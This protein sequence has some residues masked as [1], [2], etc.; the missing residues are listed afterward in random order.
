MLGRRLTRSMRQPYRSFLPLHS[1]RFFSVEKVVAL[2]E[3][4]SDRATPLSQLHEW[5]QRASRDGEGGELVLN[6]ESKVLDDGKQHWTAEFQ[7]SSSPPVLYKSGSL[8]ETTR[9]T[10]RRTVDGK[11]YYRKRRTAVQAAA[12]R[13]I[14]VIQYH[15]EGSLEPRICAEDPSTL[16]PPPISQQVAEPTST[17]PPR[18]LLNNYFQS[19]HPECLPISK[20]FQSS[21]LM[22]GEGKTWWTASFTSPADGVVY[23]AGS[24]IDKLRWGEPRYFDGKV[25]YPREKWAV[26]AVSARFLDCVAFEMGSLDQQLCHEDPSSPSTQASHPDSPNRE[27]SKKKDLAETIVGSL[28]LRVFEG[29]GDGIRE[30]NKPEVGVQSKRNG[31]TLERIMEAWSDS[32]V[33]PVDETRIASPLPMLWTPNDERRKVLADAETWYC[34]MKPG[35]IP[36]EVQGKYQLFHNPLRLATLSAGNSILWALARVSQVG[37]AFGTDE[38]S[39]EH[40]ASRIVDIL[41]ETCEPTTET[42]NA[43]LRCMEGPTW[44]KIARKADQIFQNMVDEKGGNAG[45]VLPS[46]NIETYNTM[47]MLWARAGG[48]EGKQRCEGL[49]AKIS[50]H[51]TLSPNRTT[52]MNILSCAGTRGTQLDL[53][54]A[55]SWM[56]R[57]SLNGITIDTT[58]CNSALPWSG[59]PSETWM[60]SEIWDD[61]KALFSAGFKDSDAEATENAEAVGEWMVYMKQ[62]HALEPDIVTH[63]AAIQAWVR[64]A[65]RE[66]V[67]KA[68]AIVEELMKSEHPLHSHV[69]AQTVHPI[70]AAHA[71]AGE[72][73][74]KVEE[75]FNKAARMSES[76]KHLVL[77][78]RISAMLGTAWA[79]HAKRIISS[80]KMGDFTRA[81]TAKNAAIK[82][83]HALEEQ[84]AKLKIYWED[85]ADDDAFFV[86]GSNFV[87]IVEMWSDFAV[88]M[89]TAG[90]G[91]DVSECVDEMMKAVAVHSRS[92]GLMRDVRREHEKEARFHVSTSG[93]SMLDL[94]LHHLLSTA[95][96]LYLSVALALKELDKARSESGTVSVFDPPFLSRHAPDLEGFVR[97]LHASNREIANEPTTVVYADRFSYHGDATV[98]MASNGAVCAAI[99]EGIEMHGWSQRAKTRMVATLLEFLL[100]SPSTTTPED[101]SVMRRTADMLASHEALS[102]D[103]TR[104]KLVEH[105][106]EET[107]A[108]NVTDQLRQ[109]ILDAP[110]EPFDN[111]P[112]QNTRGKPKGR[113]SSQWPNLPLD[114][115]STARRKSRGKPKG[116]KGNQRRKKM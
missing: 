51:P 12:A 62:K 35:A 9:K 17:E 57:M 5:Y 18:A 25:Y 29:A 67:E 1:S 116:R 64:T 38:S 15:A 50:S 110:P 43:Y 24:F 33:T 14:D 98:H 106:S 30:T 97:R 31:T 56:E 49:F 84:F 6:T 86:H 100:L 21:S 60:N 19:N 48:E 94:Q 70:V 59:E 41:W 37:S 101:K 54:W 80:E 69:R 10:E 40:I 93:A 8:L 102:G 61:Y 3:K 92:V 87:D 115:G 99:A 16:E 23:G 20:H 91:G 42:Y 105:L 108:S 96:R 75:W 55:R 2:E 90:E 76:N 81:T 46:A 27:L 32:V 78:S 73:P 26:Q 63:E 85:A 47:I 79:C 11:V 66:G 65:T 114:E 77:D 107:L 68:E 83:S 28:G 89:S 111:R 45:I 58:V 4:R 103:A 22:C 109:S 71:F 72:A 44:D 104:E 74:T 112:R 52:F 113:K 39:A 34:S 53:A 95:G 82:A 13:A 36:E 88:A 7:L